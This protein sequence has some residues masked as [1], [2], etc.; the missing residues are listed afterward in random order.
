VLWVARAATRLYK[1]RLVAGCLIRID[2]VGHDE[3]DASASSLPDP[4]Q[5][6]PEVG[7]GASEVIVQTRC[8]DFGKVELE[9]WAGDPGPAP[10][11]W[12]VLFDGPLTSNG[13]GFEVGDVGTF[14]H[15]NTA[16]GIY[17]VRADARRD[18]KGYVDALRFV[19]PESSDLTGQ[20]LF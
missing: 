15:L 3:V 20:A 8:P 7:I 9:V 2:E 13:T 4:P 6:I 10:P 17:R 12:K 11:N 5:P 16:P 1:K 14:F 18:S 19:F